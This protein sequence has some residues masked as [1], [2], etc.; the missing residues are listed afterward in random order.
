MFRLLPPFSAIAW[1]LY[2]L[3]G[4]ERLGLSLHAACPDCR[5]QSSRATRTDPGLVVRGQLGDVR[6]PIPALIARTCR[7]TQLA[8]T[9]GPSPRGQLE[10]IQ[11]WSSAASSEMSGIPAL[12]ARTC[13]CTQL[14]QTAGPSPRGQLERIQAW[15]PAGSAD[16]DAIA[17][18]AGASSSGRCACSWLLRAGV[19]SSSAVSSS[20]CRSGFSCA[21][22]ATLPGSAPCSCCARSIAVRD[23]L[24]S[25]DTTSH[26]KRASST[27]DASTLRKRHTFPSSWSITSSLRRSRIRSNFR[28]NNDASV[29]HSRT[30]C[31]E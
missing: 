3:C 2:L 29:T 26:S 8:Q 9:A 20:C 28:F 12:I 17:A 23:G 16:S 10:R 31:S 15:S 30:F 13:R 11:A 24:G 25:T 1:G 21:G 14:A 18:A 4:A 6:H 19:V 27:F 7:C 22:A 5:S